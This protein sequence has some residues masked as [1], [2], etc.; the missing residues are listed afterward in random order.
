MTLASWLCF[1]KVMAVF[2]LQVQIKLLISSILLMLPTISFAADPIPAWRLVW[3]DEFDR[4]NGS[5]P[6]PTKWGY[7]LG[8][9][10]WGN[11]ELETYTSRRVNSRIEDGKLIIEARQERLTGTDGRVRDYTSARLKTQGKASWTYGRFEARIK[12]PAGQGIWP[13]FWMLGANFTQVGWPACGETDIMENIGREPSRVHA[14]AHGPGYS[15]ANAPRGFYNLPNGKRFSDDFHL[16]AVEWEANVI[17]WYVDHE[18]FFTLTPAKLPPGA[19]WVFNKA[20]FIIM[21][22]AVGGDWPGTPNATTVFPQR[23]F[24][25][26]V[27]VYTRAS[28]TPPELRSSRTPDSGVLSWS[29]LFPHAR[30]ER[31]AV[32]TGPWLTAAW[33]GK[34]DGNDF[35][36]VIEPGFY[37]LRIVP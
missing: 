20:Q 34:R 23:M 37:R 3:S 25:D 27:R 17:R 31:S 24:V 7:D 9:D 14:T 8:G 32:P 2:K 4:P 21:N 28:A 13:A 15:A 18:L 12:L 10:G 16:F 33:D 19:Q 26:Y 6:D 30:L 1:V 22:V 29:G 36:I 35:A 11:N 5:G